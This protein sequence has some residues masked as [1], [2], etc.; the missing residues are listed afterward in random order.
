MEIFPTDPGVNGGTEAHI[1]ERSIKLIF[2]NK[3]KERI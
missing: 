3:F 2:D 1:I